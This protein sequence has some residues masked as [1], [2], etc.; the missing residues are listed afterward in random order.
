MLLDGLGVLEGIHAKSQLHA[1]YYR[2]S[3][4]LD[5]SFVHFLGHLGD[6]RAHR[7]SDKKLES[8]PPGLSEPGQW[9]GIKKKRRRREISVGYHGW[10]KSAKIQ[11]PGVFSL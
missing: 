1:P 11:G 2:P 10:E 4:P 5:S 6:I 7:N 3:H 9:K 8:T